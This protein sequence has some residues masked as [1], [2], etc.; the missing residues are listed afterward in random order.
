MIHKNGGRNTTSL[1]AIL[2]Y[3][4][5]YCFWD[6]ALTYDVPFLVVLQNVILKNVIIIII[7]LFIWNT[8]D[9]NKSFAQVH[10]PH[11]IKQKATIYNNTLVNFLVLSHYLIIVTQ[12]WGLCKHILH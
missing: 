11:L 12:Q 3:F 2:K 8:P 5:I 4:L 10:I 7:Y 6:L 1:A 9:K